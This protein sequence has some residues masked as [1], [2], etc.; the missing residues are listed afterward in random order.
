MFESVR[1][2]FSGGALGSRNSG[3]SAVE[4]W[5]GRAG[6]RFRKAQDRSRFLIETTSSGFELRM[7]WGPS[8]RSYIE[9]SELRLRMDLNLPGSVQ[10]LVLNQVLMERLEGETFERYTQS[11]QTMIDISTPEEMRWLAMFPKVDLSFDKS[12]RSHFCVLGADPDLALAWIKGGLGSQ[13]ERASQELLQGDTPFVL[14]TMRGK[15]YLRMQL[16]EPSPAVLTQCLELFDSAVQSAQSLT[17]QMPQGHTEWASTA[18]TAWQTHTQLDD[19]ED[20]IQR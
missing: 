11:A 18:S 17:G 10:M 3:F 1:R 20:P 19:P 12:L 2:W 16:A 4:A 7:E 8:Q 15:M 5:A 9:P 14:I 6:F 13:L